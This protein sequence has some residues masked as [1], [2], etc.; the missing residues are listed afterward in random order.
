VATQPFDVEGPIAWR[1]AGPAEPEGTIVF[2]HG[3]GGS[4]TA[5]DAQLAALSDQW[6]CVAW[7]MPGYGASEPLVPLT[8]SGIAA[9]VVALLDT[10]DVDR[11]HLCGLSFGGQQAQHVALAY[12]DRVASLTLADSSAAFGIDGTDAEAWKRART[13]ALDAGQTPA[14][15]AGAVIDA[16]SGPGFAG[17]E[18][19][20]AVAAFSR[21]SSAGLRAACD[22]LPTH[23]V[24]S[25]LSEISAPTLVLVGELDE[26]TPPSYSE[27]LSNGIAKSEL[28][29]LEGV[30][31]LSPAEAPVEF[32]NAVRTFL[33]APTTLRK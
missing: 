8:F 26:E 5:W 17:P 19:D 25:R 22:C 1:E 28:R 24:R 33:S 15:I 18:R 11:A 21:I 13:D 20:A 27:M 4:R 9:A 32:N 23:D 7:D 14:D 3:L 6:R 2:L 12:P 16:I 10:L 31:H 29:V 30:G